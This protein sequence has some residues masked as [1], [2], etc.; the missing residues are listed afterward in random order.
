MSRYYKPFGKI[1]TNHFHRRKPLNHSI[2]PLTLH[3]APQLQIWNHP[4]NLIHTAHRLHFTFEKFFV[5]KDQK[6]GWT[7]WYSTTLL[8]ISFVCVCRLDF[9]CSAKSNKPISL[10]FLPLECCCHHFDTWP[11]ENVSNLSQAILIPAIL[12]M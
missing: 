2:H 11:S 3:F 10:N 5:I 8:R 4:T 9:S 7:Q 6:G 12:G 1:I